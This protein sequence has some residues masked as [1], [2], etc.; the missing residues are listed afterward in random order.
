[1]GPSLTSVLILEVR[2][3]TRPACFLSIRN[4]QHRLRTGQVP[5]S[6][7]EMSD[8]VEVRV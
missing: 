3:G 2:C 4:P 1:M 5:G 8:R 7:W 6:A